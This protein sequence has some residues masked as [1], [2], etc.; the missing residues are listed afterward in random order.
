MPAL[1]LTPPRALVAE[2][3]G[4][5][6]RRRARFH[7]LEIAAVRALTADAIE[8]AFTVPPE[9]ADDF[10]YEPG[11][12]V[13]LR[14]A[15]D[16]DDLRRSY[17]IC[18]EPRPGELRVAIKRDRGGRFSTWAHESL[19]PGDHLDVMSPQ[20][21]FGTEVPAAAGKHFV[22]VVAGSGITPVM[23][24]VRVLLATHADSR[25][26]LIY[27]NRSAREVMFLDE[28]ADLKDRYHERL[29]LHHVLS[30]EE[31]DAE[32]LS[33]RITAERFEAMLGA[34]VPPRFVDEWFLCGPFDLVDMCR[35]ALDA[36]EVEARHVHFELFTTGRPEEGAGGPGRPV[37]EDETGESVEI[38]FTLDGRTA[39]VSSPVTAEESILN[40]ALRIRPDTP[41][42]CAGGVC[43]TCRAKV[44]E[45]AVTMRE[46][47]ALEPDE[48]EAGYVLT[49]QAHPVGERVVVDYDA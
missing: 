4:T 32:I 39:T 40:A 19:K 43:G 38:R 7:S 34:L 8:V 6:A 27:T 22:A 15:L 41:F 47:Y 1:N 14:A 23:S 12:Y 30:R 9:L 37:L 16:G 29:V 18:Q 42:A 31:R 28:L 5:R 11:Q 26:T 13:A 48:I 45:G 2:E 24:L 17:S 46:N 10:H 49:C 33:G 25:F 44:V 36:H 20:G 3:A 21:N 35:T